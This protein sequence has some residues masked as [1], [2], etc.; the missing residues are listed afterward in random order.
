MGEAAQRT[1]V[2]DPR[3]GRHMTGTVSLWWAHRGYGFITPDG[4]EEKVFFHW[5]N[6][7][8]SRA[9]KIAKAGDKVKFTYRRT[10][11]GPAAMDV[12]LTEGCGHDR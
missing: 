7:I 2:D 3:N 6:M 5:Q 11:R 1:V 4:G 12:I 8:D 9:V 10:E